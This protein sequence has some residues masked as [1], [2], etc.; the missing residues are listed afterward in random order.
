MENLIDQ[1]KLEFIVN[2]LLS[3][4]GDYGDVVVEVPVEGTSQGKDLNSILR[5]SKT[6]KEHK[7]ILIFTKYETYLN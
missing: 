7:I 4:E 6:V 5:L 3:Y 2:K 1:T